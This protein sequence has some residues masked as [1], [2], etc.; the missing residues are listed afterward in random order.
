[1][2]KVVVEDNFKDFCEWNNKGIDN[3]YSVVSYEEM[4]PKDL[5]VDEA[6]ERLKEILGR[7]VST[8]FVE[9][10]RQDNK[11]GGFT[12]PFLKYQGPGNPTNIGDPV[13]Q[14]DAYAQKHD[15]QYAHASY[16]LWK[17]KITQEQFQKRI[18]KIDQEFLK[19]NAMN[20]TGSMNPLEQVSSMIGTVGIGVK[21][22]GESIFGQQYPSTDPEKT[23]QGVQKQEGKLSNKLMQNLRSNVSS[24]SDMS[25]DTL[26]REGSTID[27][28]IPNRVQIREADS[29]QPDSQ[30]SATPENYQVSQVQGQIQDGMNLPGTGAPQAGGT[31]SDDIF[32][33]EAPPTEFGKKIS[34]YRKQHK[35][36]TFGITSDGFN[37]TNNNAVILPTCLA[38]I[39]WHLPV[40]YLTPNEFNLIPVGS[41]VKEVRITVQYRKQTVQFET[42]SSATQEAVLNQLTDVVS[43][44]GLNKTGWGSDYWP[45]QFVTGNPMK[46]TKAVNPVYGFIANSYR[47][48][49][50]EL[51]GANNNNANFLSFQ[52]KV[53]LGINWVPRNYFC[54]SS[55]RNIEQTGASNPASGGWPNLW[56]KVRQFDGD[57]IKNK[58]VLTCSYKPVMAPLKTPIRYRPIGYP[59]AANSST[60]NALTIPTVGSKGTFW[61]PT[62]TRTQSSISVYEQNTITDTTNNPQQGDALNYNIYTPIEKSQWMRT[63]AWGDGNSHVQP[64]CHVGVQPIPALSTSSLTADDDATIYTTTKG[65]FLVNCEMVVQECLPTAFPFGD[66]GSETA[67]A[68]VPYGDQIFWATQNLR[69]SNFAADVSALGQGPTRAGA[70]KGG[71]YPTQTTAQL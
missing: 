18:A 42:N 9:W 33:Y 63:G 38:E 2:A 40:M 4:I 6:R 62:V 10:Y 45:T 5:P 53:Q 54:M 55:Q 25:R 23:W 65:Y 47:G 16:R 20:I 14:A 3:A 37:G 48:L 29:T 50:A 36:Q 68:D 67:T 32:E 61:T 17:G 44:V 43:V 1:M 30:S 57:T 51:Y 19:S 12:T 21:H 69:P 26:K 7:D 59:L 66:L 15:L 27:S 46:C 49:V 8:E 22:V 13:N 70:L 34:V 64:S 31:P 56:Q 71:L 11:P 41:Y 35:I 60:G 28:N 39:P 52:P 24:R 58:I